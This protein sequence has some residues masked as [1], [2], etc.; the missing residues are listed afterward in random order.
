MLHLLGRWHL[1][2]RAN[3]LRQSLLLVLGHLLHLLLL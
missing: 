2:H 3:R 1:L